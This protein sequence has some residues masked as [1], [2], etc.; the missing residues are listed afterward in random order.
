MSRA[1]C[2]GEAIREAF[3]QLLEADPKVFLIG[4]GVRSPW[5][6]GQ[7]T[8][9]LDKIFGDERIV[10]IPISEN[11]ITGISI[12][13]AMTGLRPVVNH[14]RMD[15]MYLAMDPI[16]NHAS[17]AHYMFGGRVTAPV[18]IRGVINRGGEQ[19]AQHS[20]ALQAMFTHVPGLKVVMPATAYDA[21]GLMVAAVRDDDPVVYIDD[22]WLYEDECDVPE[23]IYEVP[24]GKGVVRVA[25][26]DL[27]VVAISY[28]ASLASKVASRLA[29]EGASIE[30]VDPR[31]L[32]PLDIEL[33]RSSVRK[34]GRLLVID[35]AWRTCGMAGEVCAQ[36]CEDAET[37]AALKAPVR[38]L[39]LPDCH[40]PA[41]AALE[42]AYYIDESKVETAIRE[43]LAGQAG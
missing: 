5:Y 6:M 1:L 36:V 27:T 15:F 23:E 34:T 10:D 26:S 3:Y 33:I 28:V 24:I 40:A 32:K 2:Y 19:A 29:E 13:G 14:P 11:S 21:K 37:F 16:F 17:V 12:G 30:V 8:R 9:D 39:T 25:G 38:R 43:A 4:V 20:Q 18:T 7:T 31:T 42:E 35:A 22:R 41:S